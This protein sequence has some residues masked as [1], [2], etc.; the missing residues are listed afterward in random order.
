MCLSN[1][2]QTEPSLAGKDIICW[3]E[4]VKDD[5]F[6]SGY[7]SPYECAEI[8]FNTILSTNLGDKKGWTGNSVFEGFH[9][10]KTRKLARDSWNNWK[11]DENNNTVVRAII[12]KGSRY[13]EGMYDDKACYCSERIIYELPNSKNN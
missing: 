7:R 2:K 3:K 4:I 6:Y 13:W 1:V 11:K 10:F 9:T 5:G 8:L 12:P